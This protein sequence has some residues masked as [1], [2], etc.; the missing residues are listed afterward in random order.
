[1]RAPL[2]TARRRRWGLKKFAAFLGVGGECECRE[3]ARCHGKGRCVLSWRA[4]LDVQ[5]KAKGPT[6]PNCR[7]FCATLQKAIQIKTGKS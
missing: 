2:P 7:G 6:P 5:K 4:C 3:A 1:M